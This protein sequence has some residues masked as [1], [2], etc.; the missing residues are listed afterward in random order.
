[1][2]KRGKMIKNK[3]LFTILILSLLMSTS[4]FADTLIIKPTTSQAKDTYVDAANPS[5][6]SCDNSIIY[7]GRIFNGDDR[8]LGIISFDLSKIPKNSTITSATL[9]FLNAVKTTSTVYFPNPYSYEIR[10]FDKQWSESSTNCPTFTSIGKNSAVNKMMITDTGTVS[11]KVN[12]AAGTEK[13]NLIVTNFVQ[14]VVNGQIV[15]NG[16]L[17]K[18]KEGAPN[19]HYRY[20]AAESKVLSQNHPTLTVVYV[21]QT[22]PP[23]D[24]DKDG[25][26]NSQ[27]K[28]PN[29]PPTE[30]NQIVTDP[31]DTFYGC[32][33]SE[34][35]SCSG[36]SPGQ[37]C[38]QGPLCFTDSN[39][40]NLENNSVIKALACSA[41]STCTMPQN[42]T[43]CP[44]QNCNQ[45]DSFFVGCYTDN[46]GLPTEYRD[47]IE[48]YQ[49]CK[50]GACQQQTCS[51]N[52]IDNENNQ[53]IDND[54]IPDFCD[55]EPC[56]SHTFLA[57]LELNL[58]CFCEGNFTNC[59][60]DFSNGC[61]RNAGTEGLCPGIPRCTTP[62]TSIPLGAGQKCLSPPSKDSL[63]GIICVQ[64]QYSCYGA[65]RAVSC[66]TPTELCPN[67]ANDYD[68]DGM[69]NDFEF[70]YGLK[71][72]DSIDKDHDND[73]DGLKN[74]QEANYSTNP[75]VKDTDADTLNDFAEV[76]L[77]LTSPVTADSDADGLID[78]DEIF[79]GTNALNPDTDADGA[80]DNDEIQ[81][82]IDWIGFTQK[83]DIKI[84][85][86][87]DG[88]LV[89]DGCA[90]DEVGG[91]DGKNNAPF[92]PDTDG[93]GLID[94]EELT[95]GKD[96]L[97]TNMFDPQ[98]ACAFKCGA[99]EPDPCEGE[100]QQTRTCNIPSG[101]ESAPKPK[102]T[103]ECKS[104]A[105]VE[106]TVPF[107]TTFS[108]ILTTLI[109]ISYY[110][111]ILRK[112]KPS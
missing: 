110:I 52:I 69:N 95:Q 18:P 34:R 82:V 55:S 27:D 48:T 56:G 28:C 16:M 54:K 68:C 81:A 12:A 77:Y 45:F 32:G 65:C 89:E 64:G 60:N 23:S 57:S 17:I 62:T 44:L 91:L 80:S 39:Y 75:L 107:F 38:Q 11:F 63:G 15:N 78:G 14:K 13:Q 105:A 67:K 42:K 102:T 53:D 108:L 72:F 40:N 100:T 101:C 49:I 2:K 61:E 96:S 36:K 109:L 51:Y 97:I 79:F 92:D 21:N 85:I 71:V 35:P 66:D 99:W 24:T 10:A 84:F 47:Y 76:F 20:F 6:K 90:G 29:T 7:I 37:V 9:T 104:A 46:K 103:K 111:F 73:G 22:T 31:N 74:E 1:M 98:N 86:S 70:N 19:T 83:S 30:I 87:K 112:Q 58:G 8:M 94:S 93:D 43:L 26:P 59:D 33:P 106:E 41:Q 25:I 5:L 50:N 88:C 4:V 3:L